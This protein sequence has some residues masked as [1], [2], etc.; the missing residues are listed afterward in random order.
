MSVR[1]VFAS[2][3]GNYVVMMGLVCLAF[4]WLGGPTVDA[5]GYVLSTINHL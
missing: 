4:Y 3:C 2:A 1:H 5:L